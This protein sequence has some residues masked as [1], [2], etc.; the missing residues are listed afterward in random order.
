[1]SALGFYLQRVLL[2]DLSFTAF[3]CLQIER[4]P[5]EVKLASDKVCQIAFVAK[6]EEIRVIDNQCDLWRF[7]LILCGKLDLYHCTMM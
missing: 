1:M 2:V 4:N 6:V 5:L 7:A 3:S